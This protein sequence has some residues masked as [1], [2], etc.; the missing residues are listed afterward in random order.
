[1]LDE[2]EFRTDR[3]RGE[4]SGG[5]LRVENSLVGVA[6][7][8]LRDRNGF[9]VVFSTLTTLVGVPRIL[10]AG[11]SLIA[12]NLGLPEG[13]LLVGLAV[14]VLALAWRVRWSTTVPLHRVQS[15]ERVDDERIRVT[16]TDGGDADDTDNFE[17]ETPTEDDAD[18]ALEI[19]RL[20]GVDGETAAESDGPNS[21]Y[22]AVRE[23]L[24]KLRE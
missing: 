7:K 9:F 23:R 3:G 4:V 24:S 1:M 15:A 17:I 21:R 2:W 11:R 20:K 16:Y 22:A 6:R 10:D 13:L 12:G 8:R 14:A 18:E 5:A 19:L